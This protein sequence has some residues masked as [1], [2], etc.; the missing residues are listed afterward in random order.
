MKV[1][2]SKIKITNRIRKE[3]V[4]IAELSA[5]IQTN[6][7][8]NPITVMPLDSEEYEYQLLAGLRRLRATEMLGDS[9]IDI[10]VVSPANAEAAL[11]IEIS[12][13]ELREEFTF[14]EKMDFA[15]MLEEIEKAKAQERM[16]AG[17]TPDDPVTHGTQGQGRSRDIVGEKI[18]MSGSQ[19]SRAKYIAD[20]APDEVIDELD[21]GKR[22]IRG[23][24]D[25]LRA[26]KKS[27]EAEPCDGSDNAALTED[28]FDELTQDAETAIDSGDSESGTPKSE[29]LVP[30]G[31]QKSSKASEKAPNDHLTDA[32]HEAL[33]RSKAFDAMSPD[34]KVAE[35]QRQLSEQRQRAN[36]AESRLSRLKELRHNDNYHKDGII[37]NLKGQVS[38]LEEELETAEARIKELEA[39]H[40]P[41]DDAKE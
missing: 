23:T 39:L 29:L 18:G 31:K 36:T 35:L 25:E 8:I 3:I 30:A 14:T 16:L 4:K 40:C 28:E 17:K 19:Y 10:K 2:I 22:S 13:N 15:R 38:R 20:N 7:L 27:K 34:E 1:Q 24:Y 33:E 12:E 37:E 9:E 41:I 11:R 21:Q 6:G 32:D 5:D 26:K